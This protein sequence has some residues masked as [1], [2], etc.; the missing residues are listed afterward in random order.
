MNRKACL[1]A[2]VAVTLPLAGCV[3][4]EPVPVVQTVQQRFDRSWDAAVG[5]MSEQGLTITTHD[6]NAGVIRG[7]RGGITV[8]AGV[9]TLPDGRIQVRFDQTGATSTDPDL[10]HRVSDGYDR[11]MGR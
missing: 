8:T 4:Y 3:V 10:I 11:R 5:A 6:R 7:E 1:L 2:V 9:Q